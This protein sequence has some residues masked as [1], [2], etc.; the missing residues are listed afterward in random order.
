MRRLRAGA[1]DGM[2]DNRESLR[3]EDDEAEVDVVDTW[4]GD[5]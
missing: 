3:G 1:K 2:V 5:L 4:G